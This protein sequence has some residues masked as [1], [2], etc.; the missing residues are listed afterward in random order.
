MN[1]AVERQTQCR[2]SCLVTSQL[3][4]VYDR[5]WALVSSCVDDVGQ[6]S[7]PSLVRG[8]CIRRVSVVLLQIVFSL[9]VGFSAM[10][11][12]TG[13]ANVREKTRVL[14]AG[15]GRPPRRPRPACVPCPDSRD[16]VSMSPT[17]EQDG[18]PCVSRRFDALATRL[19]R[20]DANTTRLRRCDTIRNT[21]DDR[22][23]TVY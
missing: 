5:L 17:R 12:K 21:I 14:P 18:G 10:S 16:H 3:L 6:L 9:C 7:P 15:D 22:I 11:R 4:R 1:F 20:R 23:R 8:T 19:R 2:V 13:A